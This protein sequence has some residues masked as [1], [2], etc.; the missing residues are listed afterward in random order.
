MSSEIT[1]NFT[2]FEQE[3]KEAR[4]RLKILQEDRID[5]SERL[6]DW[7]SETIAELSY[8]IEELDVALEEMRLQNEE[9]IVARQEVELKRQHYQELFEFAPDGYLVTDKRGM[10]QEANHAAGRLLNVPQKY[11]VGKPIDIFISSCDRDLPNSKWSQITKLF[12][13]C[14]CYSNNN[15]QKHSASNLLANNWEIYLQPRQ[16]EPL[17]VSLSIAASYNV[18]GQIESLRWSLRDLSERQAA[19][20]ERKEAEEKIREQAALLDVATDAI[21]VCDLHNKI[22][23]WNKA[24]ERLYG[25]TKEEVLGENISLLLYGDN[26]PQFAEIEQKILQNGSWHGELNQTTKAR[27][28]IIVESRWSLVQDDENKPKS[29]LVVNTDITFSKQL[30][31]RHLRSQRLE[32]IGTLANGI[33]HDLN[34]IL[35]PILGLAQFLQVEIEPASDNVKDKLKIIEINAKRSAALLKQISMFACGNPGRKVWLPVSLLLSELE[36]VIKETFPKNIAIQI[37]TPSDIWGIYGD[38]TQLHQ[39]IT[40]LCLNAKDAMPDGGKL[41]LSVR[42]IFINETY[43]SLNQDARVGPYIIISVEDTGGGIAPEILARIFDP[44]FT[45]KQLNEGTGLGLAIAANIIKNHNGFIDVSSTLGRGTQFNIFLPAEKI[46]VD[47]ELKKVRD[48]PK[49]SETTILIVDDEPFIRDM[50]ETF[51]KSCGYR[52]LSAKNGIEAIALY[53]EHKDEIDVILMDM[54]MPSMDGTSAIEELKKINPQVKI[55]VTSG[56]DSSNDGIETFVRK[57]YTT[58][59]L[60]SALHE[61]IVQSAR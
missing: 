57:P 59:E 61:N 11:L 49:G 46:I 53:A 23:F 3:V 51:L 45:T 29:I 20:R 10:I 8:G 36:L 5:S 42:N 2:R 6:Q 38:I 21:F 28:K 16:Q 1:M 25:W 44:F 17:P 18:K 35:S 54:M 55:V 34:N 27:E 22:L 19:L 47:E 31:A 13:G 60:S 7:H 4:N 37:D 14:C 12:E 40:N 52:V 9:L 56:L 15:G 32:A 58:E 41:R 33:V 39:V 50:S 43:V 24:A 30:E 48:I 26:L